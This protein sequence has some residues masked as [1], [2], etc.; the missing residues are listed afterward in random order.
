MT[1]IL[2]SNMTDIKREFQVAQYLKM[3]EFHALTG[4][5]SNSSVFEISKKAF[6]TL[7]RS[8]LHQ[9]SVSQLGTTLS[10]N[11]ISACKA[12]VCNLYTKNEM[13]GS[14]ANKLKY[15]LFSQQ[16]Q[17]NEGLLPTSDS[18]CQHK[19]RA[20]FQSIN[21]SA[22]RHWMSGRTCQNL[23]TMAGASQVAFYN[24]F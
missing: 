14:K 22:E 9:I 2:K 19:Q 1:A 13:A 15:R 10:E 21:L 12:F 18:I 8:D 20:N 5:D 6:R 23:N 17:R 11:T 16:R 7:C 24:R 4:C 3:P